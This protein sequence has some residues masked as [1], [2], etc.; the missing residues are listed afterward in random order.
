[1]GL[2]LRWLGKIFLRIVKKLSIEIKFV[3]FCCG[4]KKIS[5]FLRKRMGGIRGADRLTS[6]VSSIAG[7]RFMIRGLE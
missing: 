6:G 3:L 2:Y 1:V 7:M 5:G 4:R